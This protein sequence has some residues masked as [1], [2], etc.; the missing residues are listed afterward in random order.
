[1]LSASVSICSMYLSAFFNVAQTLSLHKAVLSISDICLHFTNL[2]TAF[3][4]DTTHDISRQSITL[5]HRSRR[6]RK[7]RRNVIGFAASL[8]DLSSDE[9][10]DENDFDAEAGEGPSLDASMSFFDTSGPLSDGDFFGWIEKVS[11]EVDG[12][13]R[14]IRRGV[15]SIAGGTT[16]AASTY[17]VLAFALEDWD[18]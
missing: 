10:E 8:Q 15:E 13:V 14:Y 3:A 11:R 12:L 16:E 1:M 18:L 17:G 6:Q 2:F 7:Q 9:D 5:R 4:G